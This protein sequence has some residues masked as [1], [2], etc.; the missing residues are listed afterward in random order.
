MIVGHVLYI[1]YILWLLLEIVFKY[2]FSLVKSIQ[3]SVSATDYVATDLCV[4]RRHNDRIDG[5]V[6]I[7]SI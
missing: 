5:L 2:Y 4:S 6:E 1:V 7:H 3:I